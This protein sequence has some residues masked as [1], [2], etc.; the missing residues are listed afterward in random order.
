MLKTLEKLLVQNDLSAEESKLAMHEIFAGA[1]PYQ[2]AS[3]LMLMRSKG[4]TVEELFGIIEA[5]RERMVRV[6]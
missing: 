1:S 3:F 4:E 6:P 5:M 2:V